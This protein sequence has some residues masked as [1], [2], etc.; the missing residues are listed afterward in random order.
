M[1]EYTLRTPALLAGI[2]TLIL[3]MFVARRVIPGSMAAMATAAFALSE[4]PIFWASD[5]KP[6]ALDLLACIGLLLVTLRY[7]ERSTKR[8]AF[9]VAAT[10]ALA[11]YFSHASVLVMAAVFLAL[12]TIAVR[13]KELRLAAP[14]VGW[15]LAGPALIHAIVA[16]N[17]PAQAYFDAFWQDGFLPL[18]FSASA[19]AAYR[20]RV[21]HFLY[22]PVGL[23]GTAFHLLAAV[24]LCAGLAGQL[25]RRT[26][27]GL[28]AVSL[29]GVVWVLSLLNIYPVGA[30]WAYSGRVLLFLVPI[31][32]LGMFAGAGM[33]GVRWIRTALALVLTG[34]IAIPTIVRLPISRGDAR[35][36]LEY[37]A[38]HARS[39]DVVY[40]HY[41]LKQ[42]LEYY[43]FEIRG[44]MLRGV[45]SQGDRQ[46]YLRDLDRM[47]GHERAWLVTAYDLYNEQVL[48]LDYMRRNAVLLDSASHVAGEARLYD[49]RSREKVAPADSL[50]EPVVAVNVA[51][52]CA[53][54][55][56]EDPAV[57]SR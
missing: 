9:A 10:G 15:L 30:R 26:P 31:V 7:L 37:A 8:R 35:E 49:F 28:L 51:T 21:V 12:G 38:D 57:G 4:F 16:L 14:M 55:F 25:L 3:F 52:D 47:R 48:L 22:D 33:F 24:L 32:Y 18:P 54:I 50:L 39:G 34:V 41:A 29:F 23:W 43:G 1:S 5:A 6:Y 45:C 11:P 17:A 27:F 56:A 36:V 44:T 20:D 53:G 40:V 42:T 13:R 19:V 46:G 2:A